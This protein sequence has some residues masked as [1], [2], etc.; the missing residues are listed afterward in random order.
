MQ[1]DRE[2]KWIRIIGP[3]EFAKERLTCIS[4]ARQIKKSV[5]EF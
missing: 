1:N 4:A 3:L 2:R 5:A